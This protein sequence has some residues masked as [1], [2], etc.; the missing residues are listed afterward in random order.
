VVD[1][2]DYAALRRRFGRV[3]VAQRPRG[4]G[5]RGTYL[6]T[7][8]ADVPALPVRSRW[9]IS[10]Y[11]GDTVLNF[12]GFIP[13]QGSPLV[14]RPSVQLTDVVGI[15][16]GFGQYSGSDFAAPARLSAVAL[17]RC[18]DAM[19]RIASALRELGYRGVFGVDFVVRGDDARALELNRRMQ[20]STWLLGEL[21][22]DA[23]A[24]PTMLRH[25]LERQGISTTSDVDLSPRAGGQL[26]IR[27][28]GVPARLL[29]APQSGVHWLRGGQLCWRRP[30]WGL[31]ECGPRD[32][33]VVNVPQP[34][35][36]LYPGAILARLVTRTALTKTNGSALT[37]YGQRILDNLHPL[38]SL[39]PDEALVAP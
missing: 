4:N 14:L 17:S 18:R 11:A 8:E 26:I 19:R 39:E 38:Y 21:E 20:G 2:V 1:S 3:F 10:A 34:G 24:L 23:G 7:A 16:S 15:G 9:L 33:A 37:T 27:H 22:L 25:V 6:I 36:L 29:R 5:G 35:T 28:T 12:H 13:V 32:C 31:L 30:G